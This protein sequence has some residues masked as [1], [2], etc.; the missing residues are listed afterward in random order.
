LG[1]S[2]L[3]EEYLSAIGRQTRKMVDY[4]D[5]LSEI[6]VW[7]ALPTSCSLGQTLLETSS[8]ISP[9]DDPAGELVL[10]QENILIQFD[11]ALIE[12]IEKFYKKML[13]PEFVDFKRE[14]PSSHIASIRMDPKI[15]C[16]RYEYLRFKGDETIKEG[17]RKL[18]ATLERTLI[19]SVIFEELENEKWKRVPEKFDQITKRLDANKIGQAFDT[20]ENNLYTVCKATLD[21]KDGVK[22]RFLNETTGIGTIELYTSP[23]LG[24]SLSKIKNYPIQIWHALQP[25]EVSWLI[26]HYDEPW[27]S[28]KVLD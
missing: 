18:N 13:G 24:A 25:M 1:F 6:L 26:R 20:L 3:S 10:R 15:I 8:Q 4:K 5:F 14:S 17:E 21:T 28:S 22:L 19:P 11:S 9:V 12:K 27:L 2:K 16:P 23:E 7:N